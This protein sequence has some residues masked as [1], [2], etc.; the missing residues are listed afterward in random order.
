M[1]F[2]HYVTFLMKMC[3]DFVKDEL[4][5]LTPVA[6]AWIVGLW[7]ADEQGFRYEPLVVHGTILDA[8]ITVFAASSSGEV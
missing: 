1:Y 5:G 4:Y 8:S 2:P 7:G 3:A 6:A